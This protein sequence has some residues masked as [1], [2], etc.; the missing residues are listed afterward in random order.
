MAALLLW[1]AAASAGTHPYYLT[2]F[3]ELAG[4]SSRGHERLL[5]SN[6]DWGQDLKALKGYL[7]R[8]NVSDLVL[9]YYGST[10]PDY[11]GR[12]YQDLFSTIEPKS[13]HVNSLDPAREYLAVSATNL[14]GVYF[15]EFGADMFYWLR[16]TEPKTVIGNNIRVYDI[17]ADARAHE[18]LANIYFLTGNPKQAQR[19]CLRA[20]KLDPRADQYD[21]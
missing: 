1:Q 6:L 12:N 13:G 11:L 19:E 14:H 7:N 8:E 21:G 2:Y 4:G 16:G 17:T 15:R 10:Q 3:N 5:D 20:L 18:H 9:S